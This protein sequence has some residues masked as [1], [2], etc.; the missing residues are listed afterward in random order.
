MKIYRNQMTGREACIA[1]AWIGL[2]L[3][4]QGCGAARVGSQ[5]PVIDANSVSR[6]KV[7][8]VGSPA[9]D[10][11]WVPPEDAFD[12][13][14][15]ESG[16]WLKGQIKAMQNRQIEFESEKLK[17]LT[18]D[19]KDIRQLRSPRIV[20]VLLVDRTQVSGP[21]TV[22]PDE[23]RVDGAAPRIF[24]RDQLQSLTPG[25]VKE[26]NYWSGKGSLGLAVRS[27]N[28]KQVEYNAQVRV[29]R[30]TPNTR[31]SLDYLG[32]VSS[33]DGVESANNN[34]ANTEFDRWLSQRLYVIVP[35]FEYYR[36][37]FQN[38]DARYTVGAGVGYDLVDRPSLNWNITLGPAF[39]KAEFT[40]VQLGEPTEK[41]AG[42]LVF[43]SRFD[44][45][46]THRTDL[47]LEYRGQYTS[48]E[49]GETA[50][51]SVATLSIELTKHFD[52]DVSFVWDRIAQPKV[53]SDGVQPKPDDYRL[54]VGV[55]INF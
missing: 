36:D 12:W 48:R 13:I 28:S 27:G 44:W 20:D 31:L 53:G 47:I 23:V 29:Q 18:F 34:R 45:D 41:G 17:G 7:A 8:A 9:P 38:L 54:V 6:S 43:G 4:V 30:R 19:W 40:S 24:A 49:V 22:T 50:H 3:A 51:H 35:F 46:I 33:V 26:R 2:V 11:S 32:N 52:L 37:P 1:V 15:L 42:A 16:E 21:V 25:G 10:L 5:P 55:G 39:Q 14:Q